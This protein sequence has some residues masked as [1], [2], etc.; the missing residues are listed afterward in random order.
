MLTGGAGDDVLSG[1][2]GADQFVL[3]SLS[4]ADA[5]V[6]QDFGRGSDTIALNGDVYGLAQ[7]VL[8]NGQFFVGD[9]AHDSSDRLIYNDQTGQLFFDADGSTAG[10][11]VVDYWTESLAL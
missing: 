11:P 2:K 6:I 7:G 9:S 1:G 8:K 10:Q 3:N 5:D 4:S